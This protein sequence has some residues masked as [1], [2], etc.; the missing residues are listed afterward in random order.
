MQYLGS[1]L[2]NDRMITVHLQGKAFSITVI[3]AYAITTNAEAAELERFYEDL[4][5]PPHAKT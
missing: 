5:W 3:K 2:K 4:L 1:N